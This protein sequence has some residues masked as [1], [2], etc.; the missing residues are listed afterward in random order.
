MWKQHMGHEIVCFISIATFRI[1]TTDVAKSSVFNVAMCYN[2]CVAN[3]FIPSLEFHQLYN[4]VASMNNH[5]SWDYEPCVKILM[6]INQMV[7][8][9]T[10]NP[11]MMKIQ[12]CNLN[13]NIFKALVR[14]NDTCCIHKGD[15]YS[16]TPIAFV[17][18][19]LKYGWMKLFIPTIYTCLI[20]IVGCNC[21][22][23]ET[24]FKQLN[25]FLVTMLGGTKI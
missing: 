24:C 9:E 1:E 3:E 4:D 8:L 14:L 13:K 25:Q 18:V 19:Y 7:Y 16:C 5:W 6:T 23:D 17:I 12:T 10:I 11:Y 21:K 20:L 22:L 2:Q 15:N